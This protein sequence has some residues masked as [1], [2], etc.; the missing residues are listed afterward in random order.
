[1][2]KRVILF[3]AGRGLKNDFA[4]VKNQYEIIAVADSDEQKWGSIYQGISVI[5]P[6]DI[7]IV[8]DINICA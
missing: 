7:D 3:G 4:S 8:N 6:C 1:M 2:K 5:R